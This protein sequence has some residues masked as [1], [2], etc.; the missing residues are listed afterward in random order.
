MQTVLT[1][2]MLA[3]TAAAA[4]AASVS[5]TWTMNVTGGP[6]GPATMLSGTLSSQVGDMKW[7]ASRAAEKSKDG[8]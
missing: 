7:T 3:F 5:G 1:V 8:R 2:V 4:V 6:H